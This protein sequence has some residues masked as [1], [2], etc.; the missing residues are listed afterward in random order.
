MKDNWDI[1]ESVLKYIG[2]ACL[3]LAII[4][5]I[6]KTLRRKDNPVLLARDNIPRNYVAVTDGR[7]PQSVTIT[8]VPVDLSADVNGSPNPGGRVLGSGRPVNQ[9]APAA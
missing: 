8:F 5:F 9:T 1:A 4:V 7:A 6:M 2:F 3:I